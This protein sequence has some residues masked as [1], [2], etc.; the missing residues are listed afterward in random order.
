[1]YWF[2]GDSSLL[3]IWCFRRSNFC[4]SLLLCTLVYAAAEFIIDEW[5][6][7]LHF[8]SV[9]IEITD[10]ISPYQNILDTVFIKISQRIEAACLYIVKFLPVIKV[11][12]HEARS[13][14][15]ARINEWS[16]SHVLCHSGAVEICIETD[17]CWILRYLILKEREFCIGFRICD[18]CHIEARCSGQRQQA[19]EKTW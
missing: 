7:G 12:C 8:R 5:P 6:K 9:Q 16:K 2:T 11:M 4:G 1:M 18:S 15:G 14:F 3:I 19:K 10:V 17:I 13:H